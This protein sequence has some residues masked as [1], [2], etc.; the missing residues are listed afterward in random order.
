MSRCPDGRKGAAEDMGSQGSIG[1]GGMGKAQIVLAAPTR[2]L[3]LAAAAARAKAAPPSPSSLLHSAAGAG[4]NK[5]NGPRSG[6][7]EKIK[8]ERKEGKNHLGRFSGKKASSS[9]EV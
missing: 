9:G 8:I 2:L 3:D 4:T 7:P 1:L 6:P 5:K